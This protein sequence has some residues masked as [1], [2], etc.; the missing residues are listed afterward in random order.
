MQIFRLWYCWGSMG[1]NGLSGMPVFP[2][3]LMV[4]CCATALEFWTC[5]PHLCKLNVSNFH[6]SCRRLL[7]LSW[8]LK[9]SIVRDSMV[10][11]SLFHLLL[12]SLRYSCLQLQFLWQWCRRFFIPFFSTSLINYDPVTVLTCCSS[13][14]VLR[15]TCVL[16]NINGYRNSRC[17][18]GL[19]ICVNNL[20]CFMKQFMSHRIDFLFFRSWCK[21][22]VA[23]LYLEGLFHKHP[24]LSCPSWYME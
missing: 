23:L 10:I 14:S 16:R 5:F 19:V 4:N 22:T 3:N 24:S 6:L 7:Q 1:N 11:P 8:W 15:S 18:S 9:L 12:N 21:C 2:P 17:S 20:L 13:G